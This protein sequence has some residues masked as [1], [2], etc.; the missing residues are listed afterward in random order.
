[1]AIDP[2]RVTKANIFNLLNPPR[3]TRDSSGFG[4]WSGVKRNSAHFLFPRQ[5]CWPNE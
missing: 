2:L 3:T 1:M 4:Q 5:T